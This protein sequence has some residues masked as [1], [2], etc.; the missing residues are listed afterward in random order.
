MVI[1]RCMH[2]NKKYFFWLPLLII[3]SSCNKE[4][5]NMPDASFVIL[6]QFPDGMREVDTI[7]EG[8]FVTFQIKKT[9]EM[10]VFY[11]GKPGYKYSQSRFFGGDNVGMSPINGK[12]ENYRYYYA[13]IDTIVCVATNYGNW[14]KEE[15][16]DVK[17]KFLIVI[18]K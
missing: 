10:V 14:S 12:L 9:A 16:R 4:K 7:Y 6:K 11:T 2:M 5:T 18:A 1:Q 3:F 13:G 15:K 8:D 17:T